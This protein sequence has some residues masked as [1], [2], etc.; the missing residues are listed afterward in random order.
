MSREQ[1]RVKLSHFLP[2]YFV[3][4]LLISFIL[5][6]VNTSPINQFKLLI[7]CFSSLLHILLALVVSKEPWIKLEMF[8]FI[9]YHL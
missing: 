7:I 6:H 8:V 2:N 1:I 5:V 4:M 9:F 3:I